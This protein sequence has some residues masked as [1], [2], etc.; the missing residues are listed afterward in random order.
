MNPNIFK[1]VLT[2]AALLSIIVYA[3]W[4]WRAEAPCFKQLD[5]IVKEKYIAGSNDCKN[6]CAKYA[7]ACLDT[8]LVPDI[9]AVFTPTG[10]HVIVGVGTKYVDCTNGK[11]S[12]RIEDF[13]QMPNKINLQDFLRENLK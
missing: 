6:K 13:G 5:K 4:S 2:G 11:V 3:V 8:G 9:Y 10:T 7:K 12:R 1:Y